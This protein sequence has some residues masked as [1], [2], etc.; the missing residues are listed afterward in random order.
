MHFYSL[1][2]LFH[3]EKCHITGVKCNYLVVNCLRSCVSLSLKKRQCELYNKHDLFRSTTQKK[4]QNKNKCVSLSHAHIHFPYQFL[5]IISLCLK[6]P[7]ACI[8]PSLNWFFRHSK[9]FTPLSLCCASTQC[10]LHMTNHLPC[11]YVISYRFRPRP[12]F[13]IFLS[14]LLAVSL[15]WN[16]NQIYL[17]S[18]HM[19]ISQWFST[20]GSWPNQASGLLQQCYANN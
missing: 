17:C 18:K 2:I 20:G 3:P 9:P 4:Q 14:R 10:I 16:S 19:Q 15:L 6:L 13:C 11:L 7:S 1:K 5:C 8:L 12:L